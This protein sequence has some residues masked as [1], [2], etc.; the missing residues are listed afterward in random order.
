MP[1]HYW[2][3]CSKCDYRAFRYRNTKRCPDCGGDLYREVAEPVSNK[4]E[5]KEG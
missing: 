5:S 3:R 1:T 4:S 2:V